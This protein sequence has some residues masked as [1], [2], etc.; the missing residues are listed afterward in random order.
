MARDD[1]P[2]FSSRAQ[3]LL[4]DSSGVPIA[5]TTVW[6][7]GPN[8]PGLL[9]PRPSTVTTKATAMERPS[10]SLRQKVCSSPGIVVSISLCGELKQRRGR[11]V[12][13][14]PGYTP[15]LR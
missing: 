6:S 12:S 14:N 1:V 4:E 13:S 5:V 15:A 8:R 10:R 7:A 3:C 11:R 2:S 9:E